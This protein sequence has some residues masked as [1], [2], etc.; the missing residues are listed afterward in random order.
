MS[1][2]TCT[3]CDGPF[4]P[5]TEGG[6]TGYLGMLPVSFCP[7]CRAGLYDLHEQLRLPVSCPKCGWTETEEES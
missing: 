4:D 3:V 5:E 1:Q 2:H 7:T 6:I